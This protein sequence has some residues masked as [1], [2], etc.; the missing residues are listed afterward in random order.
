MASEFLEVGNAL[1]IVD[2]E[3]MLMIEIVYKLHRF[4]SY[5]TQNP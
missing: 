1:L 5:D 4:A 3:K 2:D